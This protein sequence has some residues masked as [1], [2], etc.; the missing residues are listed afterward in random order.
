[1]RQPVQVHGSLTAFGATPTPA[2]LTLLQLTAGQRVARAVAALA[3]C[4]VAAIL[5]VFIPVAHFILVP[6]LLIAGL[7]L[8]FMRFRERQRFLRIHGVCPRCGLEQDFVP[9]GSTGGQPAAA[10]PTCFNRF[11]ISLGAEDAAPR[12]S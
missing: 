3:A 5:A 11:A 9:D 8:A 2:T 6:G 1:M 10:C 7:V 12:R 4:C